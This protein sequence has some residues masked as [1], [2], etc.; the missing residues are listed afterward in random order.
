MGAR[1][2]FDGVRLGIATFRGPRQ[3]AAWKAEV[4][5]L[6]KAYYPPGNY[7]FAADKGAIVVSPSF[8]FRAAQI[9]QRRLPA[10]LVKFHVN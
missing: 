9:G 2:Y 4:T 10:S 1:C 5:A 8:G 7:Y 3:Q 6:L